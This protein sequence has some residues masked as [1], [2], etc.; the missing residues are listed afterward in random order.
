[1]NTI[2]AVKAAQIQMT[3]Y[4]LILD[5]DNELKV[6][7]DDN[8]LVAKSPEKLP[9]PCLERQAMKYVYDRRRSH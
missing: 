2:Q 5:P 9:S 1:M 6:A 7:M 4:P 3:N 8:I